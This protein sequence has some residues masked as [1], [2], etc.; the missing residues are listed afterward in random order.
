MKK[1]TPSIMLYIKA[2]G[3]AAIENLEEAKQKMANLIDVEEF[4]SNPQKIK[5]YLDAAI[6][7]ITDA[8]NA[9][10]DAIHK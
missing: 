8:I 7:L 4:I 9:D 6:S 2:Q 1:L 10:Q 3:N 5:K